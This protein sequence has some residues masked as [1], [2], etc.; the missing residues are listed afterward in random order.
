MIKVM[1]KVMVIATVKVFHILRY[2][3]SERCVN[4]RGTIKFF[5]ERERKKNALRA[6]QGYLS[7]ILIEIFII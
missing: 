2:F 4:G 6:Y 1:V 3:S 7:Q 5:Q